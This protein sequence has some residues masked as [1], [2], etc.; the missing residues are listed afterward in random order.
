[1]EIERKFMIAS[2]P[3]NLDDYPSE[4]IEQV[5]LSRNPTVRV[6]RYG[7]KYILTIK[8]KGKLSHEEY[9]LDLNPDSYAH[10]F[11]KHDGFVIRKRRYRIPYGP[12]TIELDR[13]FEPVTVTYAEVEF[14]SEEEAL[15]FTPPEWFGTDLTDL[16]G[17]TNAF[18][19]YNGYI[20]E[21]K[22]ENS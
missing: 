20:G 15:A 3:E 7:D 17:Y 19:A 13:F 11:E 21:K 16:D 10:L 14:T 22:P 9:E 12:Y 5:Y 8:G 18:I 1:M 2:L 6:R 4:E